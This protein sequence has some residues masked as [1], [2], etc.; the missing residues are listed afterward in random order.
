MYS[1]GAF[2]EST[3]ADKACFDSYLLNFRVVIENFSKSTSA[4]LV[5]M[6]QYAR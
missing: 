4:D 5:I 1:F 6:L 3:V 2:S